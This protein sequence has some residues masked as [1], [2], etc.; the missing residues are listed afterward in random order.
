[1]SRPTLFRFGSPEPDSIP[2][3]SLMRTAAGGVFVMNV[4]DR[5]SK[6]VISTGMMR[7]FS[8]ACLRVEG[9]AELHDVDAV[10]AERRADRR[11]RVRLPAGNLELDDRQY[12]LAIAP[13]QTPI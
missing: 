1:M 7:P 2:S 11:R 13:S 4:N 5:S 10:L 3:A 12:F 8:C 6:T 9:L